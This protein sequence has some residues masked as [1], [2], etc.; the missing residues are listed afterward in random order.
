[1]ARAMLPLAEERA[2]LEGSLIDFVEAAWPS[3]SALGSG[4]KQVRAR[5][6]LL[7]ESLGYSQPESYTH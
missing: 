1:M 5:Q 7:S 2:A 4:W 3:Y 6:D